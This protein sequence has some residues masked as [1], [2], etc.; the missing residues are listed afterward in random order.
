MSPYTFE[1]P[2]VTCERA[3]VTCERDD[4]TFERA[5]VAFE[6]ANFITL[7]TLDTCYSISPILKRQS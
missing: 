5:D 3:N 7:A 2:N 4:A 6:R 1:R